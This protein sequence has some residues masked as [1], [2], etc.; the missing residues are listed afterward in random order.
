M[1]LEEIVKKTDNFTLYETEPGCLARRVAD[2]SLEKLLNDKVVQRVRYMVRNNISNRLIGL[3]PL[4]AIAILKNCVGMVYNE[5]GH[6]DANDYN[7]EHYPCQDKMSHL[8][9]ISLSCPGSN[10]VLMD[11]EVSNEGI[12]FS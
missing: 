10:F 8:F 2:Q 6:Y 12:Q 11:V 4:D 7:V 9:R 3:R 5:C 1:T